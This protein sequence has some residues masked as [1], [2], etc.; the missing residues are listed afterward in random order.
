MLFGYAKQHKAYRLLHATTGKVSISQSVTFA[1]TAV[2][3]PRKEATPSV[4][5]VVGDGEDNPDPS[6][7][8][9]SD[10]GICTPV[11]GSR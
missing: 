1:E 2:D 6:D 3:Q 11:P 5:D 10:E 8:A 9:T 7:H 4:I